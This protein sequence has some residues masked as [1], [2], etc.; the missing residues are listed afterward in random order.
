MCAA[1]PTP[2]ARN[3]FPRDA[4]RAIALQKKKFT[5]PVALSSTRPGDRPLPRR[6][7][8]ESFDL[9]A[10]RAR[11]ERKPSGAVGEASRRSC[12]DLSH[13]ADS[14]DHI[15]L[16][17]PRQALLR[18]QDRGAASATRASQALSVTGA[19]AG[20]ALRR[21]TAAASAPTTSSNDPAMSR[22][23]RPLTNAVFAG[24][25]RSG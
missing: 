18:E 1:F 8:R 21:R 2:E 14:S 25:T 10:L 3:I 12:R 23:L 22:S 4:L 7:S 20:A 6:A 24:S 15:D 19:G 17:R 5:E 16:V 9:L 11:C 13:F